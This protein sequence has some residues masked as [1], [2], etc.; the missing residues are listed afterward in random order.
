V[1]IPGNPFRDALEC[2]V[3]TAY[4]VIDDYMR[5]GY[6]AARS[7]RN[8][9]DGKTPMPDHTQ[10]QGNWNNPGGPMAAPFQQWLGAMQ[11]WMNAWSAFVP[12][13][14]PQQMNNA[15]PGFPGAPASAPVSV[16]V[17]VTAP[18]PVEIAASVC[19]SPGAECLPLTVGDLVGEDSARPLTGVFVASRQGTVHVAVRL[20]E[21]QPSGTYRGDIIAQERCVGSLSIVISYPRPWP[22]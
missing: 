2:G 14:F 3:Q 12:G 6:E 19:L 9:P 16:Q 7:M 15:W 20:A 10:N 8:A 5:R 22:E 17:Q 1:T 13:G 11:A 4:T 18:G 21:D